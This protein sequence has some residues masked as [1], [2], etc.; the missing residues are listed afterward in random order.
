M[1]LHPSLKI[2]GSSSKCLFRTVSSQAFYVKSVERRRTQ[3]R[4]L[5]NAIPVVRTNLL[6]GGGLLSHPLRGVDPFSISVRHLS[7][8]TQAW[9]K[10]VEESSGKKPEVHFD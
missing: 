5:L 9:Q 7:L 4:N 3:T 10:I 8:S 2:C 6:S 1:S